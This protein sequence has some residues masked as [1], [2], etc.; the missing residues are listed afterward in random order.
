MVLVYKVALADH[1][2]PLPEGLFVDEL[3]SEAEFEEPMSGMDILGETDLEPFQTRES[4]VVVMLNLICLAFSDKNFHINE[5][6]FLKDLTKSFGFSD[7]EYQNFVD[8]GQSQAL[9]M[10]E[11][12]LMVSRAAR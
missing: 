2:V 4:R 11:A 6:V 10:S 8:R 7:D 12:N 9:L 3:M 1:R 5:T